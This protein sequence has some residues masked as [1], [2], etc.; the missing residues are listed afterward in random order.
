MHRFIFILMLALLPL[1]GWAGEA[2][3]TQMAIKLAQNNATHLVANKTINT[4]TTAIN[5]LKIAVFETL[6]PHSASQTPD[7]G[8]H[9]A[10]SVSASEDKANAATEATD[11]TSDSS[12]TCNHCQA[13]H[14][15]GLTNVTVSRTSYSVVNALPEVQLKRFA[16]ADLA[17]SQKPPTL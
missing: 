12:H 6:E 16:S 10:A 4:P 5:S 1:R 9:T 15:V 13:C 2:M 17:L 3:A 7:C 11:V 14:A 8:M